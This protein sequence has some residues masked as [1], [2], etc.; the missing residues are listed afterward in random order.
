MSC[1]PVREAELIK[2]GWRR[3]FMASEPRL[4]EAVQQYR[5][6]GFEV[7]LEAVDPAAC[8]SGGQCTACFQQ[9]EAAALLKV[10]FTRPRA[11]GGGEDLF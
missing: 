3:Q 8:Q 4:G 6:L 11:S 10:I 7:R 9:P 5:E 2:Q 1:S